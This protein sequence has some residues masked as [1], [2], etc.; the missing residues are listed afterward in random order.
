MNQLIL[1]HFQWKVDSKNYF[2]HSSER[3]FF[4][5]G[6]FRLTGKHF[7]GIGVT[8]GPIRMG[9]TKESGPTGAKKVTSVQ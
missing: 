3:R 5:S 4:K 7:N 6:I 2:R 8:K 1:S 9:N